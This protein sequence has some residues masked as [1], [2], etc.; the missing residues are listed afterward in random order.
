MSSLVEFCH[1][2]GEKVENV[3]RLTER[4]TDAKQKIIRKAQLS[5]HLRCAINIYWYIYLKQHVHH[6]TFFLHNTR[7]HD[8][9]VS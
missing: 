8:P 7:P 5:F 6:D 1:V 9:I 3:E 2:V 4:Q